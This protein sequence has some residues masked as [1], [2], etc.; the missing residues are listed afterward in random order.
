MEA[1]L[2]EIVD[3]VMNSIK[4]FFIFDFQIARLKQ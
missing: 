3:Q 1:K 4:L 2:Q